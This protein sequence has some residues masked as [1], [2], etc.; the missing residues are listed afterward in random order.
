MT[1]WFGL[2]GAAILIALFIILLR[3]SAG[4]AES[5]EKELFR[6]CRGDREMMERLV[7]YELKRGQNKERKAAV[8]AAIDSLKRDNR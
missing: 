4:T 5:R 6:L 3:N 8:K 2:L 7:S 1:Q